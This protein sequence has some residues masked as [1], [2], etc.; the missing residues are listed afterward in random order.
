MDVITIIVHNIYKVWEQE[1]IE[2]ILLM[3]IKGFSDYV[4]RLKLTLQMK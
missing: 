4:S 3:D 1:K 2:A